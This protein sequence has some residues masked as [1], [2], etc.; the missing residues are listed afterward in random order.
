MVCIVICEWKF[1]KKSVVRDFENNISKTKQDRAV[2]VTQLFQNFIFKNAPQFS[3]YSHL[4]IATYCK[5]G[6]ICWAKL[7]QFLEYRESFPV[8]N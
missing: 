4:K 2:S 8:N 7:L 6:K 5:Q 1:S 3:K